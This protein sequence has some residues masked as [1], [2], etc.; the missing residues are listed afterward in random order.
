MVPTKSNY[1]KLSITTTPDHVEPLSES[2]MA[3]G[4]LSVSFQDAED[5]PI[6]QTA[7]AETP[8]WQRTK[9]DALFDANVSIETI[10]K[11]LQ[12]EHSNF[13]DLDF[14]VE[15][16]EE[17]D[18]VRITQQQFHPQEYGKNLWVCPAWDD[19]H[20]LPGTVVKID[21]GLAFGTGTHPTTASCLAWLAE[22]PPKAK[23]VIDYGCGS[24][25]L[26]L[27]ALALGAKKVW[28]V[29]H[30]QQAIIATNNNAA[31]NDFY[32]P[33]RLL[34][35]LPEACSATKSD[36]VIANILANPLIELAP[37]LIEFLQPNGILVLSGILA[38]E[39]DRVA[40]AYDK[41]LTRIDT[42]LQDE[43]ARLV[44]VLHHP[45]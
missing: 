16:I 36:Y 42:T 9:V 26:S 27:A 40:S 39:I 12:S 43:W 8:L 37:T 1:L 21:P 31:L 14:Y 11:A 25:I 7:V 45:G 10:I 28:A 30:D 34:V 5:E 35:S 13:M 3:L 20:D 22:N 17:Q 32:D 15:K 4:A 2:L 41:M 38:K 6:F 24:G 23:Q 44:W 19:A 29:D 33:K 18:W